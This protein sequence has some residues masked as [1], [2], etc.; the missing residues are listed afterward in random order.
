M[1]SIGI[2]GQ[3]S[4]FAGGGAFDAEGEAIMA[5]LLLEKGER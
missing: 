1:R 5:A 4:S 2:V 3:A